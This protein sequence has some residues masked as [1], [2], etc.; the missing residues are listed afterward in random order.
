MAYRNKEACLAE[1][2]RLGIDVDG[3]SWPEL[4]KVVSEAIKSNGDKVI[5]NPEM[6]RRR[7]E[8]EMLRPY[9]GKT[10]VLSPELSPERYRLV[11]YDEDLGYD[12]EVEERQFDIDDRTGV[13]DKSGN[14]K[15]D[16]DNV[17]DQF[18]DYTTGTYRIKKRGDRKVI[19]MSSVPKENAGMI[20]RPGIDYATLVTWQG[21][22]GYL[23]KHWRYPNVKAL[24]IESGY[25][26]EYKHL[27]KDEPNVWYAAGKQ[28]VCD[29]HLVHKVLEEIQEKQ[30]QKNLENE[31][32]RKQLGI[33]EESYP[34]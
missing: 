5:E 29:V 18:H 3:M 24:L 30:K 32:R 11:K 4:Q 31:A 8:A 10:I 21:R 20:F 17:I 2:K 26:Q 22:V 9:V 14:S 6:H 7:V 23:W 28:L 33:Q 34:W 1:A 27:F 19:A 15:V 16:Y 12:I 25:Y 13:Y